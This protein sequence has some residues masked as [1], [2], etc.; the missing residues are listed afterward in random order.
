VLVDD[1]QIVHFDFA[2]DSTVDAESVEFAPPPGTAHLRTPPRHTRHGLNRPGSCG[3]SRVIRFQPSANRSVGQRR[4]RFEL[5]GSDIIEVAV[6][7]GGV[8]PVD[9]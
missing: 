7:P 2:F 3:G 5:G 8:G 4:T 1:P 9:S 6:E